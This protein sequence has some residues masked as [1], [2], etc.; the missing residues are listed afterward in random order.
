M[1][2][3]AIAALVIA[4]V[5]AFGGRLAQLA[6]LRLRGAWLVAVALAVQV[7]VISVVPDVPQPVAAGLH[8]AT[9]AAAVYVVWLNRCHIGV[10]V[11]GLGAG[12]N[13]LAITANGGT[14]PA[15]GAAM[16]SAQ[17]V[18]HPHHFANS[19]P[20]SDAHLRFLGD[21]WSTPS[22]LPLHNV[23]SIGD[24]VIL[25]GA[26]VLVHGVCGTRPYH[27]GR[28]IVVRRAATPA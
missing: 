9:Y 28:R 23:F 17:V 14:L 25:L 5:P 10:V 16:T 2:M 19:A 20:L 11:L 21:V 24:V 3:L 1:L 13:A 8:V 15:S 22:W 18:D 6:T 26:A 7:L 4:S 12:L 27:A